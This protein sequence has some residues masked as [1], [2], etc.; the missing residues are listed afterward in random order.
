MA[1]A[2]AAAH[3]FSYLDA[4]R[5]SIPLDAVGTSI[6]FRLVSNF[7]RTERL[8]DALRYLD[9]IKAQ[10]QSRPEVY[11]QF[12]NILKD[13]KSQVI[14]TPEVI[15]RVL[16]LFQGNRMLIQGLNA[17]VPRGYHIDVSEDHVVT[18][19]EQPTRRSAN[20]V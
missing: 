5:T 17:W 13:F 16:T 11:D 10:Y 15:R 4:A 9:T 6:P 18:P 14:D 8:T 12:M 20:L 19:R 2:L 3:A 1:R 7:T